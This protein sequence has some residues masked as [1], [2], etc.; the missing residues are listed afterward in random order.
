[1]GWSGCLRCLL[2]L[3][4]FVGNGCRTSVDGSFCSVVVPLEVVGGAGSLLP[5]APVSGV[6]EVGGPLATGLPVIVMYTSRAAF[7]ELTP[8]FLL[9]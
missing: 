7:S 1:M 3:R 5:R 9:M 6:K 2:G 4:P 8:G